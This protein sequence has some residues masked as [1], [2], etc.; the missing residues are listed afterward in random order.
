MW[1]PGNDPH[2]DGCKLGKWRRNRKHTERSWL[3]NNMWHYGWYP[4]LCVWVPVRESFCLFWRE[5]LTKSLRMRSPTKPKGRGKEGPREESTEEKRRR[6]SAEWS[7]RDELAGENSQE[8]VNQEMRFRQ[9]GEQS[10]EVSMANGF[11]RVFARVHARVSSENAQKVSQT[12]P[13]CAWTWPKSVFVRLF[14]S[15]PLSVVFCVSVKNVRCPRPEMRKTTR[16]I[17]G[18]EWFKEAEMVGSAGGYWHKYIQYR[19]PS[20]YKYKSDVLEADTRANIGKEG[21][22]T[23]ATQKRTHDSKIR[24]KSCLELISNWN[25]FSSS[26]LT[27]KPNS[28]VPNASPLTPTGPWKQ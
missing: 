24:D 5:T 16:W 3:I 21:S 15:Y 9:R 12:F 7:R 17:T 4:F 22:D 18:H 13:S 27:R 19:K 23:R 8:K 2:V 14:F 25:F 20:L 11:V 6:Q 1:G 26:H 28:C 10:T